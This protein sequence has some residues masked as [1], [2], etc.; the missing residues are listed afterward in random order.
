MNTTAYLENC[1]QIPREQRDQLLK[2]AR[3]AKELCEILDYKDDTW[4]I[5]YENLKE[6]VLNEN[7]PIIDKNDSKTDNYRDTRL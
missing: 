7:N 6:A 2:I 5:P 1:V 3:E 4:W